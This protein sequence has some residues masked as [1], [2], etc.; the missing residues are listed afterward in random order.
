MFE[1]P[2][3]GRE[4]ARNYTS[5]SMA[6]SVVCVA[7]ISILRRMSFCKLLKGILTAFVHR[8]NWTGDEGYVWEHA[9]KSQQTCT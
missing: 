1:E 7:T 3:P 4:V 6:R 2:L 8:F 5:L 9:V